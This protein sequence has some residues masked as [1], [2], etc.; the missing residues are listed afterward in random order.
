MPL[1]I[2]SDIE[3]KNINVTGVNILQEYSTEEQRIGTWVDKRPLFRKIIQVE[4]LPNNSSTTIAHNISDIEDIIDYWG[5]SSNA[6]NTSSMTLPFAAV[7]NTHTV[8]LSV[9]KQNIFITTGMD[10]SQYVKNYITLLYTHPGTSRNVAFNNDAG[11][12]SLSG[13][14]VLTSGM[15]S[16]NDSD[17]RVNGNTEENQEYDLMI[18]TDATEMTFNVKIG[19]VELVDT[20]VL[21]TNETLFVKINCPTANSNWTISSTQQNIIDLVETTGNVVSNDVIYVGKSGPIG[22]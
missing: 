16:W 15:I 7:D 22:V 17:S 10:R 2:Y 12:A 18:S 5:I 13:S 11:Y 20:V 9:N 6:A 4:P 1:Q 3:G 14:L 8:Q 19:L 21:N